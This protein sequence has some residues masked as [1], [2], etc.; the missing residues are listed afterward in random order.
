M[1]HV[2]VCILMFLVYGSLWAMEQDEPCGPDEVQRLYELCQRGVVDNVLKDFPINTLGIDGSTLLHMAIKEP[3][4]SEEKRKRLV[5]AILKRDVDTNIQDDDGDTALHLSVA[6]GYPE[7]SSLLLAK[8]AQPNIRNNENKAPLQLTMDHFDEK[9]PDLIKILVSNK[10]DINCQDKEG[11]T[12]L[13]LSTELIIKAQNP[14]ISLFPSALALSGTLIAHGADFTIKNNEGETF[15]H[16]FARFCEKSSDAFLMGLKAHTELVSRSHRPGAVIV[17]LMA[18]KR[19]ECV[20]SML[21]R[22]VLI[23]LTQFIEKELLLTEFFAQKRPAWPYQG[24]PLYPDPTA[25]QIF[26]E[27]ASRSRGLGDA[28]RWLTLKALFDPDT[29]P[30]KSLSEKEILEISLG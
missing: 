12:L 13:H 21:P 17:M 29:G 9:T 6:D 18:R 25:A 8:G 7:I 1:K 15:L 14:I 23:Y 24:T 11:N 20:L 2:V 19:K 27:K 16:T 28:R 3:C 5:E 10:A 22:R 4:E 30:E 26:Q